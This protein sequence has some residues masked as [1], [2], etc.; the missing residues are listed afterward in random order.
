MIYVC[1]RFLE[2]YV[3]TYFVYFYRRKYLEWK[4]P[5]YY[6]LFFVFI[7]ICLLTIL[8][9]LLFFTLLLS[10]NKISFINIVWSNFPLGYSFPKFLPFLFQYIYKSLTSYPFY[11]SISID[12]CLIDPFS[13]QWCFWGLS[14]K[15]TL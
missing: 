10:Y 11:F 5:Q 12:L 15:Q 9:N 2:F 7:L 3:D 4:T 6:N 13:C 14:R 1:V 8:Y